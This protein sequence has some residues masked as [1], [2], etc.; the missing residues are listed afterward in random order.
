MGNGLLNGLKGYPKVYTKTFNN[1]NA[2]TKH[3]TDTNEINWYGTFCF[4][5]MV[6][7]S[8]YKTHGIL[9]DGE[10]NFY[11]PSFSLTGLSVDAMSPSVMNS[12][13][14]LQG[15]IRF[16]GILKKVD[17]VFSEAITAKT[18]ISLNVYKIN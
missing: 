18:A 2:S 16:S 1:L 17:I 7:G 14:G 9:I 4:F 10:G 11:F 8:Q 6:I 13:N 5:D 15:A 12:K 3:F